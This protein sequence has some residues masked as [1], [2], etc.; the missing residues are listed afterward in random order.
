MRTS[1]QLGQVGT[2]LEA[3][4]CKATRAAFMARQPRMEQEK[5][6]Y[7]SGGATFHTERISSW[8]A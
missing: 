3:L 1:A 6:S 2:S 4:R 5:E 7:M 8:L